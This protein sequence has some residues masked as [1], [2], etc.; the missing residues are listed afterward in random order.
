MEIESYAGIRYVP[1]QFTQTGTHSLACRAPL[2][3]PSGGSADV[4]SA[5]TLASDR[6]AA[7]P[8][9]TDRRK[10]TG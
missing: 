7:V 6:D 4:A 5:I 8:A 10:G 3:C 2:P 9:G 1:S